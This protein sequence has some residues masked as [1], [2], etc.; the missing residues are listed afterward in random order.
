MTSKGVLTRAISPIPA[1]SI[2]DLQLEDNVYKPDFEIT[3]KYQAFSN[4]LVRLSLLGLG[5]YGFLIKLS[6]GSTENA[7]NFEHAIQRH[8]I[9]AVC[10]VLAFA[11]CSVCALMN[12]F[13]ATKCLSHQL[14]ISRYLGRLEG[15]RW[16]D[17][18][19]ESFRR[20]IREQQQAQRSVLTLGNQSLFLATVALANGAGF[21]AVCSVLVIL[22]H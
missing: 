16:D 15:N 7:S 14:V 17:D 10:G 9:L 3:A 11:I 19:K 5:A 13:L 18:A 20:V 8:S 4:E 21:T 2:A 22:N 1:R 12:G 6:S